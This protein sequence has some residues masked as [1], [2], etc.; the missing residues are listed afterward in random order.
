[1]LPSSFVL[2]WFMLY[3]KLVTCVGVTPKRS[4]TATRSCSSTLR[5]N[6]PVR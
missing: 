6:F 2:R 3:K 1:M 5:L 4:A